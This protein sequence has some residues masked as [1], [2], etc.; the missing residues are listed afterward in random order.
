MLPLRARVDLGVMAMK[1]YTAVLML[2]HYGNL[3]IKFSISHLLARSLN[4]KQFY[5]TRRWD[6]IRCY[7]FGPEWTW[8]WWQWRGTPYPP[9]LQDWSL[10]I[11]FFNIISRNLVGEDLPLLQRKNR[12]ILQSQPT[13]LEKIWGDL[14]QLR[15]QWKT[16]S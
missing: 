8:E 4:V 1:G 9:K 2:Q 10:A 5:L 3:T 14:M 6:P 7:H 15:L 13:G 12:Y 11:R 16:P